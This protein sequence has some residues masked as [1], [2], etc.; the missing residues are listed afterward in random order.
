MAN[1]RYG[2]VLGSNKEDYLKAP[3]FL[4]TA[5]ARQQK[6]IPRVP[7]NRPKTPTKSSQPQKSRGLFD[8][9]NFSNIEMDSDRSMLLMILALLSGKDSET[10]E[11]L[12]LALIYIML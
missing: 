5:N 11:L 12:M 10:D 2:K 4:R 8:M 6:N 1:N 3:D 9:L 7:V